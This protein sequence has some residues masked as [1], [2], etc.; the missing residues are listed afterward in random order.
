[1]KSIKLIIKSSGLWCTWDFI[2]EYGAKLQNRIDYS[3]TGEF[4]AIRETL[5]SIQRGSYIDIGSGK[6]IT[7]S[8][9][10]NFYRMGWRGVSID[11]IPSNGIWTK[12]LRPGDTFIEGLIGDGNSAIEFH[13]FWPYEYSTSNTLAFKLLRTHQHARYLSTTTHLP[14]KIA[15]LQTH[16]K[17]PYFISIDIEGSELEALETMNFQDNLLKLI[18]IEF[19]D[20][21]S[22]TP[23]TSPLQ[24]KMEENGFFEVRRTSKSI[25]YSNTKI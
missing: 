7:N 4:S 22:E 9:S 18:C 15:T 10:Y 12:I 25:I 6:P 16:M 21:N 24:K 20:D 19:A 3:E 23:S 17:I 14:I 13:R 8:N 11:P 2:K 5:P 1:M